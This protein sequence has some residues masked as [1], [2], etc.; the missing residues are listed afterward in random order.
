MKIVNCPH[1]QKRLPTA[2]MRLCSAAVH[3]TRT[4]RINAS[5][6]PEQR[7]AAAKKA[8]AARWAKTADARA[9]KKAAKLPPGAPTLVLLLTVALSAIDCGSSTPA[10]P[11]DGGS[12]ARSVA[13][14][15]TPQADASPDAGGGDV[16]GAPETAPQR[17]GGAEAGAE[18]SADV[19]GVD[20]TPG[21][22]GEAGGVSMCP[23]YAP[24][25][26]TPVPG[27]TECGQP[28]GNVGWAGGLV[29]KNG[30]ECYLCTN[31]KP[32][33]AGDV[34]VCDDYHP[35]GETSSYAVDCLAD[36]AACCTECM[37]AGWWTHNYVDDHGN[38]WNTKIDPLTWHQIQTD[39]QS[40]GGTA[41]L[42][43]RCG[44]APDGGSRG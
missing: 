39:D 42:Y 36:V 5:L 3:A 37:P 34:V 12:D 11:V 20:A 22:A 2:T 23:A 19:G 43:P 41:P 17:D 24:Q 29:D 4:E 18:A 44:A 1:C 32:Y 14:D 38:I 7:R 8:I 9:A 15:A 30:R 25:L 28:P 33:P 6:T 40:A 35:K 26:I 27:F 10:I 21:E 31:G 13:P 16:Q